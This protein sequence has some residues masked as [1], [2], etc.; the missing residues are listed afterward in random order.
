M[1]N[2]SLQLEWPTEPELKCLEHSPRHLSREKPGIDADISSN[3]N[4][5][6]LG[7][8]RS[9]PN[10]LYEDNIRGGRARR[11]SCRC[12]DYFL[13]ALDVFGITLMSTWQ[14]LQGVENASLAKSDGLDHA[15]SARLSF[16][17]DPLTQV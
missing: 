17:N 1:S 2:C 15:V 7:K 3:A 4:F 14:R 9:G 5:G 12:V 8:A 13:L 16:K 6:L 11:A 10:V